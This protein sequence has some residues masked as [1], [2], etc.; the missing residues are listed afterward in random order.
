MYSVGGTTYYMPASPIAMWEL[1]V[2]NS[3]N[4]IYS[5]TTFDSP[6]AGRVRERWFAALPFAKKN[7]SDDYYAGSSQIVFQAVTTGTGALGQ[8]LSWYVG[9]SNSDKAAHAGSATGT[10]YA[11]DPEHSD[12]SQL[13]FSKLNVAGNYERIAIVALA[14]DPFAG[15]GSA[16]DSA[17]TE[18]RVAQYMLWYEDYIVPNIQDL[19]NDS[20]FNHDQ[21]VA[22]VGAEG[23][24]YKSVKDYLVNISISNLDAADALASIYDLLSAGGAEELGHVGTGPNGIAGWSGSPP[25]AVKSRYE[26]NFGWLHG[27][28]VPVAEGGRS[29][30]AGAVQTFTIDLT[31]LNS[32]YT[33]GG[34]WSVFTW[35]V[36]LSPWAGFRTVIHAAMVSLVTVWSGM[37]V[38]NELRRQ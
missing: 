7:G 27:P 19:R 10:A 24:W 6:Q 26:E 15:S 22:A 4:S 11:F 28:K 1:K 8:V 25:A 34:H 2:L 20:K 17:W 5:S 9:A 16:A 37:M 38:W 33:H 3:G 31:A 30:D 23:N 29:G 14:S 12:G 21:M 13:C 36:D 18:T 32:F 35:T